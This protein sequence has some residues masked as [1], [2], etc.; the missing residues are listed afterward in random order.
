MGYPFGVYEEIIGDYRGLYEETIRDKYLCFT[1]TPEFTPR[2]SF[3]Y[4][5]ILNI[6]TP[7]N[8]FWI[9]HMSISNPQCH[10]SYKSNLLD[11]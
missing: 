2:E 8:H 1:D 10:H 11:L 3:M 9:Y 4:I 6:L 7:G 5:S